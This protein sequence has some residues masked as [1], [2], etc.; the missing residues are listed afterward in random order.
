MCLAVWSCDCVA[1]HCGVGNEE[2]WAIY[3]QGEVV[4]PN[5]LCFEKLSISYCPIYYRANKQLVAHVY[6]CI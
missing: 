5:E 1:R 2:V 4:R 6:T 3:M